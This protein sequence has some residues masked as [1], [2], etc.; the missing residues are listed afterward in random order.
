MVRGAE[1]GVPGAGPALLRP[2][3]PSCLLPELLALREAVG[4]SD[5]LLRSR[6]VVPCGDS[7]GQRTRPGGR[8]PVGRAAE[9]TG[10]TGQGLQLSRRAEPWTV[11]AETPGSG[12]GPRAHP[13]PRPASGGRGAWTG[14]GG[15]QS[16]PGAPVTRS[17][18]GAKGKTDRS[19]GCPSGRRLPA[20]TP[21]RLREKAAA[22]QGGCGGGAL[23]LTSRRTCLSLSPGRRMAAFPGSRSVIRKRTSLSQGCCFKN[24]AG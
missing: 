6:S 7:L 24:E 9:V 4:G 13:S 3:D 19:P 21:Q 11:P 12:W 16:C 14:V 18:D 5:T 15:A 10:W 17:A 20:G 1:W 8:V 23:P 22:V 2:S